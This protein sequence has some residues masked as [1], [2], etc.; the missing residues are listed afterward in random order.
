MAEADPFA[1]ARALVTP[2]LRAAA[3]RMNPAT[4]QVIGYHF[5]WWDEHGRPLDGDSGKA[6]RP[7]LAMLAAEAVG[8]AA[9]RSK[10]AGVAVELAHNYSL[11]HDDVMDEDRTRRHRP[12]AWT[13]Y[14]VP[15]AILAGDA[16]I[17][18]STEALA[19]DGPPLSTKGVERLNAAMLRLV[20]GQAA[21]TAF[22][23]RRDVTLDE[24]M[25]MAA[26][27][28]GALF[29]VACELGAL[30]AGSSPE[31]V[32]QLRQFGEHLGLAF[33]LADDLLGIWG[34]PDNT[35]KPVLADLRARKKS[36]PVVAALNAGNGA[37]ARLAELY[38]RSEPL[39]D[40]ELRTCADLIEQ[41]GARAWAHEETHRQLDAAMACLQAANPEPGAAAELAALAQR[42]CTA[43]AKQVPEQE[44]F[45][46]PDVQITRTARVNPRLEAARA[47]TLSWAEEIGLI[48][49]DADVLPWTTAE[50]AANDFG[51]L[52]SLKFADAPIDELNTIGDWYTWLFHLDDHL[53]EAF[54]RTGDLAG[55]KAYL[56]RFP[57]FM[58]VDLD[59][60]APIPA[61]PAERG[62]ADLWSRVAPR[63]STGWRSRIRG[64]VE[65]LL[66]GHLQELRCA[67]SQRTAT[68]VEYVEMK[69]K[70]NGGAVS[71][72]LA[73]FARCAE[74]PQAVAD[75]PTVRAL[76]DAVS[77][78]ALLLNDLFSYEREV[79]DGVETANMVLVLK[80][81]LG[82]DTRR[83]VAATNDMLTARVRQFEHI[84]DV[85]IPEMC[86]EHSLTPE[87]RAVVAGYVDTLRDWLPGWL[88]WQ[89]RTSRYGE[90]DA[91][92]VVESISRRLA[93]PTGFGTATARR[94]LNCAR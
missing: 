73:E 84:A 12:T 29:A 13:V 67:T 34:D 14:G 27:K 91:P 89:K 64:A 53:V 8:S 72:C 15:A 47:H 42:L 74:L 43:Q 77:E 18:L 26:D 10:N 46:L 23:A 93:G 70:T 51:L 68:P 56:A 25:T 58:P 59:L 71:S 7:A 40:A 4:R 11:L 3:D 31:R 36:L 65:Q 62:L 48:D 86:D 33:Q 9:E 85:E 39:D 32:W 22:E 87:E 21:D 79:V 80:E 24:C 60:E 2:G 55:A 52:C 6:V 16:L 1:R 19:N 20:D 63:M 90:A 44:S 69:R 94:L 30:S 5:G 66:A 41:A 88:E 35:G 54:G 38:Y 78:S 17:T 82:C 75:G 81:F 92:V 61:I 49:P 76:V 57:P 28:T 37:A 45:E 83:A 50:L